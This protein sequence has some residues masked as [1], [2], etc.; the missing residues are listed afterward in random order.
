M[1]HEVFGKINYA[2][3]VKEVGGKTWDGRPCPTWEELTDVIR[4]GWCA[5]AEDVLDALT[6]SVLA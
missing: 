1:D 6:R 3:Y 4:A 2:G 5:G